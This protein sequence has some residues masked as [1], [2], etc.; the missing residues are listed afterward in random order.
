MTT[1]FPYCSRIA[2][3][4]E[5]RRLFLFL[6]DTT[7]LYNILLLTVFDYSQLFELYRIMPSSREDR[8]IFEQNEGL[9]P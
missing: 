7:R 5:V 9:R 3:Q 4:E 2:I 8:L 1:D 6:K